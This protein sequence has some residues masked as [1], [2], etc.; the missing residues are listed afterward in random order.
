MPRL[1]LI[2]IST[3]VFLT[4][5][6][7]QAHIDG[8]AKKVIMSAPSK[9]CLLYTSFPLWETLSRPFRAYLPR[10]NALPSPLGWIQAAFCGKIGLRRLL[11]QISR[12]MILPGTILRECFQIGCGKMKI[13]GLTGGSGTGKGTVAARMRELGAGWVDADAVYRLSLIHIYRFIPFRF[14]AATRRPR[15]LAASLR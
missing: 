7:A 4:K 1:S 14:S 13:I 2:H 11:P 15:P 8:G 5:E 3:G 6:K 12:H 9:D 10:C